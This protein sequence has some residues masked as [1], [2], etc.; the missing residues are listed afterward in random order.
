M[1]RKGKGEGITAFLSLHAWLWH[2]EKIIV[3]GF[4][5]ASSWPRHWDHADEGFQER[6][7]LLE[8]GHDTRS[9]CI[10]EHQSGGI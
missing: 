6:I 1:G 2:S 8:G 10:K 9:G 3:E 7:E 5:E 4:M